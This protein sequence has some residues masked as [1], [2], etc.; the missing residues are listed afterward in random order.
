MSK[1]L[2]NIVIVVLLIAS[3][4]FGYLAYL[5]IKPL[6]NSDIQNN[7]I[8]D[9]AIK[10]TE[11]PFDRVI[12]FDAI[13]K[14]NKDII[15]WIYIPGT[16]I[17]YPIFR[18]SSNSEYLKKDSEGNYNPIGSL[19]TYY[20]SKDFM[21]DANQF[22]F[23]HNMIEFKMFG[24]LRMYLKDEDYRKNKSKIYIYTERKTSEVEMFSIFTCYKNDNVYQS[25]KM[26]LGSSEYLDR[27]TEL[28]NRNEC[29][30]L[31]VSKKNLDWVNSQIYTLSTCHGNIGTPYRL[32]ISGVTTKEKYLVD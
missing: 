17:D 31:K 5:E 12:D 18:G 24:E 7:A 23:G 4:L 29:K 16:S 27:I 28:Q 13:K 22:I 26:E 19:F 1:K 25:H 15:G 21:S 8:K 11:N 9:V 2:S 10:E 3:T 32:L 20:D 14:V 6:L 30:D